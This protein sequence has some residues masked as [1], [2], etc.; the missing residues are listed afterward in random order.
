MVSLVE[1]NILEFIDFLS[2]HRPYKYTQLINTIRLD[3]KYD[4]LFSTQVP[5]LTAASEL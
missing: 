5:L 1:R 4:Q 3:I 2:D